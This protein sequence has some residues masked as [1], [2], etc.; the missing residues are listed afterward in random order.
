M[1]CVRQLKRW[2]KQNASPKQLLADP[3]LNKTMLR[4]AVVA[5]KHGMP[6]WGFLG[7]G[8]HHLCD[9][10]NSLATLHKNSAP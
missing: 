5:C 8:E 4:D 7:L 2:Q 6:D 9:D 10:T 1:D 3:M